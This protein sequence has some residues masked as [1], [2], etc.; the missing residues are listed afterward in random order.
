MSYDDFFIWLKQRESIINPA[1]SD[2]WAY[3][4]GYEQAAI[5]LNGLQNYFDDKL[6]ALL[7]YNLATHYIIMQNYQLED[8]SEN[9]LYSK[10]EI[11]DKSS[12]LVA[13]ASDEGSSA[14]YHLPEFLNTMDLMA[15]DLFLTPYGKK[16]YGILLQIN[17]MPVLL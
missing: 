5:M 6:Y 7:I 14:N 2:F 10:Y 11:A 9:P 15:M 13:S 3:K 12:G 8:G 1:N 17:I 4:D 16:V